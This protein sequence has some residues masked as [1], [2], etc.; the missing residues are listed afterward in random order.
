MLNSFSV[1]ILLFE[2]TAAVIE[3]TETKAQIS[4]LLEI[5]GKLGIKELVRTGRIAIAE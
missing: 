4:L 5:L 1:R 2:K 3:A